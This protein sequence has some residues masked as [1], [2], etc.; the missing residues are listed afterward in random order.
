MPGAANAVA[1]R[2]HPTRD[3]AAD[4]ISR[5]L[6][7]EFAGTPVP[8][9]VLTDLRTVA[10]TNDFSIR[11]W[12]RALLTHPEFY[13]PE[14]RSGRVRTPVEYVVAALAATGHR[15]A[16]ATPLWLMEGM[17]QRPLYPPNVSG[18]RHNAYWINAGAMARRTDAAR[19]FM[20]RSMQGYWDGDGLIRLAGGTL[21][22]SQIEDAYR[23]RPADLV[24]RFLELMR[25]DPEPAM[26]Q[27]L[28]DFSVASYRWERPDLIA[29][30]LVAPDFHLA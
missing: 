10:V 5:K 14:V 13:T 20:W 23:D 24:D 19:S 15:S 17:G 22:R 8:A 9:G 11:P 12:L 28:V 25:L 30:I 16:V 1:N 6:W 27:A 21:S 18:W 4:F 26:R 2:G 7:A 29:M 3:V